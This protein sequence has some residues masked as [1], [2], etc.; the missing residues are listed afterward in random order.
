MPPERS[1]VDMNSVQ[2]DVTKVGQKRK[3]TEFI[4]LRKRANKAL[5]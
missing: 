2:M 5:L 3:W 1:I 4:W